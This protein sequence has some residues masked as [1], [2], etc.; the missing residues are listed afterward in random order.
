MFILI[1]KFYNGIRGQDW[2]TL[3]SKTSL[4]GHQYFKNQKILHKKSGFLTSHE[5]WEDE[6]LLS[7][8]SV[9]QPG[10]FEAPSCPAHLGELLPSGSSDRS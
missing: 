3:C 10:G 4:I 9:G 5:M 8:R 7:L 2:Y 6:A 1:H